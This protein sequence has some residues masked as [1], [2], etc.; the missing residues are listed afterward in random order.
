MNEY[1]KNRGLGWCYLAIIHQ[2]GLS[3]SQFEMEAGF[4]KEF[5][6]VELDW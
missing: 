5:F 2:I 3:R 6:N 1:G 4:M